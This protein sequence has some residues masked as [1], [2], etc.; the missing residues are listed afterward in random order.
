M[1]V[2][3]SVVGPRFSA[4]SVTVTS[5]EVAVATMVVLRDPGEVFLLRHTPGPDAV[6]W[7]ERIDPMTLECVARSADLAGGPTWPGGMAAHADGSL[8]VVFGNHA[9]CLGSD[10]SVRASVALPRTR[11]YNSFVVLPDGHVVTKDFGGMLPG[12]TE[13]VDPELTC[14]LLVLAPGSLDVV[15]RAEIPERSIA[16][17][18]AD[19]SRVYVV[20][21][22]SLFRLD[23]DGS[24]LAID[25][26][27]APRY[28]TVDGQTYGWDAVLALGAVWFLDNGFGSER[29]AGTFRGQGVN[30]AP[31]HLVR[32]D[33]TTGA[34]QLTE[35]CGEPGGVVANPP[36]VDETR[37][38]VVAFDSGNGV[39]AALDIGDD[40]TL[41]P[42]WRRD[43]NHASHMLLFPD[44]GELVTTDH[45]A[46]QFADD[47]VVLD[48][49]SGEE[50][51]RVATGSPL[52][53]VVF[54]AAGFDRDVYYC[55]FST[56]ARVAAS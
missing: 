11:P 10:L 48:I 28:R 30:T 4:G 39:L 18:S 53:S 34:A 5:R 21:T 27:F 32:V 25:E 44:T 20:G 22:D 12:A 3:H 13:V 52:Q 43:Q 35:V 23:W 33:A 49:E 6:A 55:S 56:L 40:G 45:D 50:R 38:I 8:Y 47:F 16:R 42:R 26:S 9:H 19:G 37:S 36:L 46:E 24:A 29:Y 51:V 41:T 54:H 1:Q 2:P 14:E 17:V 31:L 7:V 15:A